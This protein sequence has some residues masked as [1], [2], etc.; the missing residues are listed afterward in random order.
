MPNPGR[1]AA[2]RRH[3]VVRR[4]RPDG[5]VLLESAQPLE[6]YPASVTDH[7][8]HWAAADAARLL[9]AERG[10]DG[11]W[12]K[13]TYGEALTAAPAIGQS[14]LDRGFSARRPLMILSGNS[15]GHLLITLAALAPISVAYSL[16]S[17]A[18]AR[19]RAIEELIRPGAVYA[20]DATWFA[21][22]LAA[23]STRLVIS[24]HGGPAEHSLAALLGTVPCAAVETASSSVTGSTV[25]K[26]LFTSGSTGAPKGVITAHGMLCANQQMVRQVWPFLIQE[27]PV[28]LDWLPW[29][30]AFGGSHNVNLILASGGT[31]YVD[32][33]RPAPDLFPRTLANM[34]D[35]SPTLAFNVPAGFA[36]LVPALENDRDLAARFFSRLRLIFNAAA[37]LPPALRARLQ[38]LG[39]SVTGRDVPV[40]GSW[41][42]TETSP[43][44]TSAHYS[45]IDPRC[46][47][48]ALPGVTVRLVPAEGDGHEIRVRGPR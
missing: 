32:D 17:K 5:T 41:G 6:A 36:Q 20:E 12:A 3:P 45:F 15:T 14:L 46:I 16:R 4:D 24:A 28:L 35:V 33:G 7:L 22:A 48:V 13:Q 27:R 23:L 1:G 30:H 38:A 8:R 19:I 47:G 25:A 18:Y 21:S 43:A 34:C 29:S 42:T 37:A 2:L 31:L 9:V 44:S 26:I 10:P 40:T 39:H 11:R